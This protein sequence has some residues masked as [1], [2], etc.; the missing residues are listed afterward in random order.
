MCTSELLSILEAVLTVSP[1]RQ[2]LRF[3]LPTTLATTGPVGKNSATRLALSAFTQRNNHT[4]TQSRTH[5]HAHAHRQ[6]L[7]TYTHTCTYTSTTSIAC[8]FSCPPSH[9][10]IIPE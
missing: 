5:M 3:L 2:Y 1:K 7:H 9:K 6:L 8:N 4:I 10:R